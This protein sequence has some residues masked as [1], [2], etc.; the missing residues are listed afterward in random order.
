MSETAIADIIPAR[1][2]HR[3]GLHLYRK[4]VIAEENLY[5]DDCANIMKSNLHVNGDL[6]IAGDMRLDS[7][8]VS[9]T[10]K[11]ILKGKICARNSVIKANSLE[12][13]GLIDCPVIE[14]GSMLCHSSV[15]TTCLSIIKGGTIKGILIAEEKAVIGD[16]LVVETISAK[17]IQISKNA[18]ID[19]KTIVAKSVVT[20]EKLADYTAMTQRESKKNEPLTLDELRS[21][22]GLDLGKLCIKMVTNKNQCDIAE[23]CNGWFLFGLRPLSLDDYGKTWGV[24]RNKPMEE[25]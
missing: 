21:L 3:K 22:R 17:H 8:T 10:G 7:A 11:L 2:N 9:V 23:V 14:C 15:L 20:V 24:Y 1:D 12:A 6:V 4:N 18:R 13:V 25:I 19:A 16:T 5:I